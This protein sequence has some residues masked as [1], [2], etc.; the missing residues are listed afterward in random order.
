M[1]K[2]KSRSGG[3]RTFLLGMFSKSSSSSQDNEESAAVEEIIT[4]KSID[5]YTTVN[6]D[7]DR[8]PE[9][10]PF[11]FQDNKDKDNSSSLGDDDLSTFSSKHSATFLQNNKWRIIAFLVC[12]AVFLMAIAAVALTFGILHAQQS[13]TV[14]FA[15]IFNKGGKDTDTNASASTKVPTQNDPFPPAFAP[16][17]ATPSPTVGNVFAPSYDDVKLPPPTAPPTESDPLADVKADLLAIIANVSSASL[18]DLEETSAAPTTTTTTF[19][20]TPQQLA[21]DWLINDPSYWNYTD[22]TL[23]QRWVLATFYYSTDGDAWD[24]DVFPP[25]VQLGKAAWL[26][27][28]SECLWESTNQGANGDVCNDN[29]E[30]FALHLR[31]VGLN[32]TLPEELGLLTSL[33]IIF[34]N[35]N[36]DLYGTIPTQLGLLTDLEKLQLSN[37]GVEGTLPTE[38][39]AWTRLSVAGFGNNEL[40]GTMPTELGLWTSLVTLGVQGNELTGELPSEMGRLIRLENLSMEHNRFTGTIPLQWENMASLESFSVQKNYLTGDM[41]EDLCYMKDLDVLMADCRNDNL[42]CWCCTECFTPRPKN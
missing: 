39:G 9:E 6:D 29:G 20:S 2:S 23:I 16:L 21:Y 24:T 3:G 19:D 30:I 11:D 13:D 12:L 8:D 35:G 1:D 27:Y 7:G 42:Y 33:E 38:I 40:V 31:N 15:G 34:A 18:A 4:P 37:N 22:T 5:V 17:V 28:S 25:D 10:L 32:G 14:L 26:N 41:P 36:P